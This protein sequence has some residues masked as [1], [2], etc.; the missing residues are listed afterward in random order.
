MKFYFSS[1]KVLFAGILLVGCSDG[2]SAQNYWM[3]HAGS[4]TADEANSISLDANN[5]TYST[6]YFTGTAT[7]GST[8][9]NNT[10]VSDIFVTKTDANGNFQWAVKAGDGGSDRG[11]AIKSDANGNNYVTGFYYG[12]AKFGTQTITS[13][14]LQDAFVAKYDANGNLK[15]VVSAGGSLSDIGNAITIDNVGNVV[16]AG[17]F[18]GTAT[19]GSFILTG[20]GSNVNVFTAKLDSSNGTF[21]W[22]KSGVGPHTDRA[23]GVACDPSGNVYVTGQYSDTITFDNIHYTSLYDGIFLVKYN[24]AGTEQWFTT[25]GGATNNICTAIAADNNSNVYLTGNFTGSLSFFAHT[26]TTIT[27]IYTNKVFVAKYDATGNLSW[28][29]DDG[30]SNPIEANSIAVDSLGNPYIIGN[31]ECIMNEYADKYGQGT[32]NTVGFWDIFGT[33]YSSSSG[34]W[35][36][37]RQIG[38]HKNNYGNGIAVSK[39]GDVYTAGSFDKDMILATGANF[40]GYNTLLWTYGLC[41]NAYCADNYYGQFAYFNTTGNL[42]V[43]IA[44][45]FDLSR[46]TYDF[47]LRTGNGCNKSYEGVC[48]NDDNPNNYFNCLDTAKFCGIGNLLANSNTCN[49]KGAETGPQ[50]MYKWSTGS[51]QNIIPVSTKGWYYVTMTSADGCFKSKDSIY[52]VID[53]LPKPTLSDNVVINT[54]AT[55]PFPINLCMDSCILTGGNFGTDSVWW[56]GTKK[57]NTVSISVTK[58]G[59]YCFNIQ[60]KLGCRNEVCVV[61]T[62]DSTLPKIAPKM[63][64]PG[65]SH[66]TISM[67]KNSEFAM[68]VYDTISNPS[69]NQTKCIPPPSS[70][71]ITWTATP[72]TIAYAPL[73]NCSEFDADHFLPADSGWYKITATITR[74]NYCDTNIMIVTDSIYVKLYPQPKITISGAPMICPGSQEYLVASG[75]SN[76][77]W[78]TGSTKDSI[79]VSTPGYYFVSSNNIYNCLT[80]VA[81]LLSNPPQPNIT[82]L[83]SNGLICPGDS[84]KLLCSGSGTFQWQ[85]P[86]GPIGGNNAIIYV[87]VPGNY[88]CILTDSLGCVLLSNSVTV[89]QYS[90]PYLVSSKNAEVCFGDSAKISVI[91]PPGAIITWL[92]PLSGHDSV[93]YISTSGTYTCTVLSC[94]ILSTE[95]ITVLISNPIATITPS[96][97]TNLCAGDSV[98]LTGNTGVIFYDWNPGGNSNQTITVSKAGT[99]TLTTIDGFGCSAS[100]SIIINKSTKMKDSITAFSNIACFGGNT[101][102]ISVGISGGT[103][104]YTYVWSSG[105]GTSATSTGLSAGSYT[106]TTIDAYGC[107]QSTTEILK[108]TTS[109]LVYN[110]TSTN[111]SCFGNNTGTANATVSGGAPTYTYLWNPGS[112]SSANLT[113]LTAGTY[114]VTITDSAG[115]AVTSSVTITQPAQTTT[116]LNPISATCI[117]NDGSISISVTGGTSPYTYLWNPGGNTNSSITG[118]STGNYSVTITDAN[119]CI[120]T[121]SG[122]VGLN[123]TFSVNIKGDDSICNGQTDTLAASGATTYTWSNGSTASSIIITPATSTLY[124]VIGTTGVCTDTIPHKVTIYKQLATSRIPNDTICPGTPVVLKVSLVGG[125]PAYTYT[126]NN[127]VTN[128]S[129]GPITVYPDSNTTYKVVITDA[130]DYKASDSVKIIVRA[131]G[132]ASFFAN[133]D[134]IAGGQTVIFNNT[135]KNT[136]SYFWTFG[137]G[138]SSTLGTPTHIYT[139]TGS[140]EVILIGY[141]VYGC[142][143]TAIEDVFITPEII[144]PNVFTPNGDGRNETLIFT[145]GGATCF[146]VDLYNRWGQIVYESGNMYGGWDGRIRQTGA[147]A[148]DGVYYYIINY[149][150]AKNASHKLDGF[151]QLIRNK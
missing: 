86:T 101:G 131:K 138:S 14:G 6:G 147:L 96:G 94:G 32:F 73:T 8:V 50:F 45:P 29:V 95:N 88:Y 38:G 63:I 77:N 142:A 7:F 24:N 16:I 115:C 134:T 103:P 97:P 130:C 78:S 20:S 111:V 82:M 52:V 83:P 112:Y 35:L 62:I 21:L 93:Q 28:A 80:T 61:V 13:A 113:N 72:N 90:T 58:T 92:P 15:W 122:T 121:T 9:L 75:A 105:G 108:Q 36:W 49:P 19:F 74:E 124:Y 110:T 46:Q 107:T 39:A 42:D 132:N 136:T 89:S 148:S 57:A 54:N 69:A 10:G 125:K 149:C 65:S 40:I 17:Q 67:C 146:H 85:G 79:L 27:N 59:I 60:D 25:A 18:T 11:L 68:F 31:F 102:I 1:F 140:Y 51:T 44:Q 33:E 109:S 150:D 2:L 56:T 127:G 4:A 106:I 151:V 117:N 123:K 128:N 135:S 81:F 64:C 12:T 120:D 70:T 114:T 47:Y 66:D 37:S 139:G 43:Y 84:V 26:I 126:W 141:N 48:I 34:A 5:N 55:V 98:T 30:S 53:T 104:S 71:I 99:Y 118:L 145:I 144:I 116:I 3:Q 129:A 119:G 23:L 91:A 41:N 76:Y 22:A 137:D 100:N 133:P 143:D 87:N